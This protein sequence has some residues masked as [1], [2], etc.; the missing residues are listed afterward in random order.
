MVNLKYKKFRCGHCRQF[1][2][3]YE[4]I[5]EN[6]AH[7]TN[8]ILGRMDGTANQVAGLS[9]NSYPTIRFYPADKKQETHD[10]EGD[11]TEE[12]IYKFIQKHA[13][14]THSFPSPTKAEL[15]QIIH[16]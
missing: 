3:L 1:A 6:L 8:L 13:H 12:N 11:R 10:L 2:P 5:G 14:Y 15:Q 7:N 9:V 4:K 16:H